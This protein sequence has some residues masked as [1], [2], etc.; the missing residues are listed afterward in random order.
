MSLILFLY[1][2]HQCIKL[3]I[4]YH[5]TIQPIS[6]MCTNTPV[7][8]YLCLMLV[9]QDLIKVLMQIVM[10]DCTSASLLQK[11]KRF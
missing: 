9:V 1:L 5:L 3:T 10:I 6:L 8:A 2:Y 4:V 11:V 7:V